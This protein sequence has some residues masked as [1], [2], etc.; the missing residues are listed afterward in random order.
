MQLGWQFLC[1]EWEMHKNG[2]NLQNGI[3]LSF[4]TLLSAE[5]CIN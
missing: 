4:N 5:A 3:Y 2:N 1:D